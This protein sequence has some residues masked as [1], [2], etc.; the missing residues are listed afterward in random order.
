MNVLK[1]WQPD[2]AANE[3][4]RS[5]T[6]FATGLKLVNCYRGEAL[7]CRFPNARHLGEA[8]TQGGDFAVDPTRQR[9]ELTRAGIDL[10]DRRRGC[11]KGLRR[12]R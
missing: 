4:G 11:G 1:H 8:R 12:D 3:R 2:S 10:I 7:F 9:F 6:P 5:Q